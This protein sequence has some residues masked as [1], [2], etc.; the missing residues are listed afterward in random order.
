MNAEVSR[1]R[2]EQRSLLG[3]GSYS[4]YFVVKL[5]EAGSL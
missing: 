3:E 1:E 2:A 4:S 5:N